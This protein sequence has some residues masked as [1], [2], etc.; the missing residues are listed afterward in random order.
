VTEDTDLR[1]PSGEAYRRCF[2]CGTENPIGL[3]LRFRRADRG[4]RAEF[5]PRPEYQGWDNILHG[6]I[7]LTMLDETLA[8]AALFAAGPA[9]T[10]EIQAR[11]RRP[12]SM[13]QEFSLFGEVT[14]AR[15]GLVQAH[16]TISD[17]QGLL[18]AEADG[19]F[20]LIR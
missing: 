11:L 10:A 8:Y 7:I 14:R 20:M 18:I 6:G 1:E 3:G 12:A 17:D 4:V 5:R 16:A 2:G 19:K 13:D 9:V 15:L